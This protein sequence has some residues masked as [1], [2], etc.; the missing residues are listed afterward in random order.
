MANKVAFTQNVT[1]HTVA[2][3]AGSG[4][5]SLVITQ[6]TSNNTLEL[7]A[8]LT[9]PSATPNLEDLNNVS[10]GAAIGQVIQWDGAA[11]QPITLDIP[12]NNINDSGAITGQVLI[13]DGT[14]W[15]PGD[16]NASGSSQLTADINVTDTV[17]NVSS[18]TTLPTGTELEDI[19]NTMLVSYQNPVMS[20]SGWF[21]TIAEHG[22]GF[23]DTNFTLA[24]TN[25][26]NI[27]GTVIG[28]W[29]FVDSFMV[30]SL[31]TAV[32]ADGITNTGAITGT[33][34]VTDTNA[35][36][37]IT[38]RTGAA[39]LTVSGFQDTNGD[40]IAPRTTT[41]TV[42]YRYWVVDSTT[43]LTPDGFTLAQGNTML[44]TADSSLNGTGAGCIESGLLASVSS[45]GFTAAGNHDY[46]YWIYPEA[47]NVS[48]VVMNG[49]VN[50]YAG[51]TADKTTAVIHMGSFDCTNQHGEVVRME[52]LRSK[53][54]NAFAPGTVITVA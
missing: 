17:G 25:D 7:N 10:A 41:S 12:A 44:T 29:T 5:N 30:N 11:W 53:V 31:G 23:F 40:A 2:V 18:G 39:A 27:D 19:F 24:F 51:D 36:Q 52:M 32:A 3:T 9:L 45:L 16:N 4:G 33:Y 14:N 35:G 42:R 22:S 21:S 20:L 8:G 50:L 46:V 15:I 1:Q 37:G 49:S 26:S 13:F 34:L 28:T 48:S 54:N 6:N 38:Q 43:A 47:F